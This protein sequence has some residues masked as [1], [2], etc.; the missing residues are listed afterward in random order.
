[1][2]KNIRI[3]LSLI[4]CMA[5]LVSGVTITPSTSQ[6]RSKAKTAYSKILKKKKYA[7]ETMFAVHDLNSDG[8]PELLIYTDYN[9]FGMVIYTYKNG[10]VK[11][12]NTPEYPVY[13]SLYSS[14]SRKSFM[15]YRGGPADDAGMPFT[16]IEYKFKSGK[17]VE[18]N[19]FYGYS[20]G[21]AEGYYMNGEEISKSK[22][23]SIKKKFNKEVM[24]LEN[25]A[26]NRKSKGVN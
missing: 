4:L 24:F 7:K 14:K 2:K 15:F 18:K 16:M 6:A 3:I 12:L 26:A 23:Q 5:I 1:M 20:S 19:S 11:K 21:S 8:T 25:T 13:G 22:F 10:K 9:F 17:I